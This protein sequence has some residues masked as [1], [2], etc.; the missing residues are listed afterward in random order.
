MPPQLLRVL[1]KLLETSRDSTTLAVGC[2]D[3]AQFVSHISHGAAQ[4]G[5]ACG[6]CVAG[7][8]GVLQGGQGWPAQP[9]CRVFAQRRHPHPRRSSPYP[10]AAA[11]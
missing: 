9:H 4:P 3:L 2:F 11:S 10:Q 7:V 1:L 5:L 8:Q 6:R